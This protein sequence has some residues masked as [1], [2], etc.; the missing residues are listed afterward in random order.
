MVTLGVDGLVSGLD[1][2]SIIT[3]LMK[4]EAKPQDLLK[5]QLSAT[6]AKA[7]AYRAVNTRFDAIRTAAEAL[8]AGS[9]AGRPDG[10]QHARPRS[11][12]T[13][14]P[15]RRRRAP[16]SASGVEQAG[17]RPSRSSAAEPGPRPRP[18][19]PTQRAAGLAHQG[20]RQPEG[21]RS[22]R[23]I[24]VPAD[25]T[26]TDAHDRDQRRRRTACTPPSSRSAPASSG[27]RSPATAT[28]TDGARTLQGGR[29][30]RRPTAESGVRGRAGAQRDAQIIDLDGTGRRR[31]APRPTPSAT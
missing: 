28:G 14:T 1:T 9:L 23:I 11:T 8:T 15:G 6:Q 5:T 2:T 31:S 10:H 26:L 21:T 7:T 25:A 12:A 24:V 3:N 17:R 18:R 4:V 27:C 22:A 29:R 30:G 20:A 13:A 16:A 19:S